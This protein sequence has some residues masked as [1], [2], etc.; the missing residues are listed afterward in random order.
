MDYQLGP[1]QMVDGV[2]ALFTI[3][4]LMAEP[5]A[6]VD[7]RSTRMEGARAKVEARIDADV[8]PQLFQLIRANDGAIPG[9]SLIDVFG[10]P[11]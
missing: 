11:P 6:Q 8:E 4:A 10:T 5:R 9:L 3:F 7:L 2:K 1:E